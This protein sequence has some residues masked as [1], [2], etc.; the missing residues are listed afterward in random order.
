VLIEAAIS[1]IDGKTI[2]H[3]SS[4]WPVHIPRLI[5]V[6]GLA[7]YYALTVSAYRNML[8]KHK[9]WDASSSIKKSI[10]YSKNYPWLT[11]NKA[12]EV[13]TLKLDTFIKENDINFID[14]I[15]MDIQGAEE[16]AF[17]GACHTLSRTKYL[18]TEYGEVSC[19]LDA[20]TREETVSLLQKHNFEVI[21]DYS[22]QKKIGNLLFVNKNF[23]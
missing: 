4:G 8:G 1:D 23:I 21:P 13:K 12:L 22:D 5:R 3:I 15:W 17:E 11:F 19:Y 16:E 14:F 7:K 18:Y 10:S 20:M 9:E 2:L 6:S